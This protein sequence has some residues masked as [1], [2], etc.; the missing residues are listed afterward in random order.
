MLRAH[1]LRSIETAQST[2]RSRRPE[3]LTPEWIAERRSA[4]IESLGVEC[5]PVLD[6]PKDRLV[7]EL[8]RRDFII[9]KRLVEVIDDLPLPVDVYKPLTSDPSPLVL[10]VPGHWMENGRLHADFQRN[11]IALTRSGMTVA[12]YDPIDE[13]ERFVDWRAHSEYAMIAAGI[14][15]FGLLLAEA[16]ALLRL[17]MARNDI[18]QSRV[19]VT[20]ASGGGQTAMF[21]PIVDE[22]VRAI[23]PVCYACDL[24]KLITRLSRLNYVG[25][26]DMCPQMI[27]LADEVTYADIIGLAAP[28]PACYINASRD[29]NFPPEDAEQ[30]VEDARRY[31]ETRGAGASLELVTVPGEHAYGWNATETACRFF[32]RVF[33]HDSSSSARSADSELHCEDSELQKVPYTVDFMSVSA[34]PERIDR[35]PTQAPDWDQETRVLPEGVDARPASVAIAQRIA[36]KAGGPDAASRDDIW[37]AFGLYSAAPAR[38][39]NIL[40]TWEFDGIR[41][42]RVVVEPEEGVE[43]PLLLFVPERYDGFAAPLIVLSRNGMLDAVEVFDVSALVAAGWAVIACEPRG[44]GETAGVE[45]EVSTTALLLRRHL[46]CPAGR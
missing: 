36:S 4:I 1:L 8:V 34:S 45:F 10:H 37:N 25:G 40:R 21:F 24:G 2:V 32:R 26:M 38:P 27:G 18:D 43:L 7:R 23:V 31:Y 28:V 30:V 20:G 33:D 6:A 44:Y 29:Q 14:S 17:L 39:P 12:I 15:F 19:G 5:V 16:R 46:F 11:A 22:S 9:E 41:I 35:L 3:P 42:E 13:G